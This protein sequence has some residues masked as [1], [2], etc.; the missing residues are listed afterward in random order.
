M[1]LGGFSLS[2]HLYVL[3]RFI[4]GQNPGQNM[5]VAD[6]FLRQPILK[7]PY[8]KDIS[9]A[10]E[11]TKRSSILLIST[12]E[13]TF[14]KAFAGFPFCLR[15]NFG[16]NPSKRKGPRPKSRAF[17][18]LR[19]SVMDSCLFNSRP[20]GAIGS[21]EELNTQKCDVYG[22][23]P[24]SG[25]SYSSSQAFPCKWY[26]PSRPQSYRPRSRCLSGSGRGSYSSD[27]AQL[28]A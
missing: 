19:S 15:A 2:V 12:T 3:F 6:G 7:K 21:L 8:F 13:M 5:S 17:P 28:A 9:F 1:I 24:S 14:R 23:I 26:E 20:H 16:Q 10:H 22:F 4:F 18:L 11:Q 27:S 25:I